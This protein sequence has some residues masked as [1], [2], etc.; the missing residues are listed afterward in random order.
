VWSG[1]TSIKQGLLFDPEDSGRSSGTSVDVCRLHG[2]IS[3]KAELFI[4]T[5]VGTS[6]PTNST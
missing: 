5:A 3:E 4:V 2:V 6:N 1:E